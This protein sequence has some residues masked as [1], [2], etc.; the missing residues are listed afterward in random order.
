MP[1]PVP[2]S[3][4]IQPHQLFSVRYSPYSPALSDHKFITSS[5]RPNSP[6]TPL[7]AQA[8]NAPVFVPKS[9]NLRLQQHSTPPPSPSISRTHASVA[10]LLRLNGESQ[11]PIASDLLRYR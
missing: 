10:F 9:S 6:A 2:Q 4:C 7:T 8:V 1:F 5:T 3:P 11:Q